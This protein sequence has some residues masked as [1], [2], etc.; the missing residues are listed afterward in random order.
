MCST[1]TKF[2]KNNIR[3]SFLRQNKAKNKYLFKTYLFLALF[4]QKEYPSLCFPIQHS[5]KKKKIT[6]PISA[7]LHQLSNAIKFPLLKPG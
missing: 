1:Y 7:S 3:N 6:F 4:C 5:L 2:L